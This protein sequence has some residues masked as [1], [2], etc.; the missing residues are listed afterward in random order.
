MGTKASRF[1]KYKQETGQYFGVL[2]ATFPE[3]K[4]QVLIAP[5]FHWASSAFNIAASGILFKILVQ[6]CIFAFMAVFV[7]KLGIYF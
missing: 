2:F 4:H 7:G 6:A 3:R 5:Q 1:G